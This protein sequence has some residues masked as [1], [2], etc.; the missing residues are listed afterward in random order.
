M[1]LLS[2]VSSVSV[3]FH[4]MLATSD[5]WFVIPVVIGLLVDWEITRTDVRFVQ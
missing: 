1:H 2:R 3:I 4:A 5:K